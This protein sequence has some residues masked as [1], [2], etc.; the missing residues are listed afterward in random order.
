MTLRVAV[1]VG[2]TAVGKTRLGVR[3][4]H[5]L[6]S[7]ILSADSRQVYR[8]LDLGTGKDLHEYAS[9]DPPVP[10]HLIDLVPP[11]EVYTLYHYQRDCYRL[12]RRFACRAG[13][14]SGERPLVMVGGSGLY[15]EA[16]VRDFRIADVP[17]D[18][19]LRRELSTRRHADL[20][21]EL[22]RR[23]PDLAAATD[24]ASSRRVIRALEV[25]QHRLEVGAATSGSLGVPIRFDVFVVRA[26]IGWLRQRI[27]VRLD[28][29]LRAG[30][31]EE[32]ASLLAA[33]VPRGRLDALGLEYREIA[34]FLHGETSREVMRESLATRIG[35]LAK[36]QQTFFRG[37]PRRGV[38]VTFIDP[39]DLETILSVLQPS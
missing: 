32:V 11:T 22:L 24:T 13:Y 27:A 38:P 10:Y 9:V 26:E 8:G 16:V 34:A 12:L 20:V 19:G 6:G 2:P 39:G 25:V 18:P 23:D 4:A 14:A 5:H 15:V 28:E 29:R 31:V 37:L 30:M 35:Q 33:G 3:L 36:R 17:A 21:D 7:E 1:I